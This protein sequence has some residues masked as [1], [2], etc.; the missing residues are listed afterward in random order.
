LPEAE[1]IQ[2]A[3]H[4]DAWAF[5]CLYWSH[6]RR[7]YGL[8]FRM[9]GNQDE[10]EDLT[11]EVFLRLFRKINTFRG[12]SALSTWL[13][14]VTVN[15]VLMRL[16]KKPMMEI[17]LEN[18][19]G[20][21]N[22]ADDAAREVGTSDPRLLGLVDRLNLQRA[23]DQLA[24]SSKAIF[25]LHDIEGFKHDEIAEILGCSAGN[26][27]SQLNRARMRL[28]RLLRRP[29]GSAPV[30]RSSFSVSNF[31]QRPGRNGRV[32]LSTFSGRTQ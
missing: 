11:Q 7:V 25:I 9:V 22:E 15:V 3:T 27:K 30:S 6:V 16:R 18:P 24:P 19:N 10:A 20:L 14:R 28:R 21:D 8:C 2:M 26:S 1:A 23:V 13:Y 4:G 31:R 29:R 17:P 32:P 5:E 12:Q